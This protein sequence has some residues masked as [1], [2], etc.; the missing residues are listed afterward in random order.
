ML[1]DSINKAINVMCL[2]ELCR[3]VLSRKPLQRR[4]KSPD[5]PLGS[6]SRSTT[7]LCLSPNEKVDNES[8]KLPFRV[9]A[10]SG[11]SLDRPSTPVAAARRLRRDTF[12]VHYQYAAL[13]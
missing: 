9:A 3:P 6:S 4:H 10:L 13:V 5:L 12:Q 7:A 1:N 11:F 2:A 8:R